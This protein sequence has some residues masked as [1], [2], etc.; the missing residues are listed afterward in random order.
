MNAQRAPNSISEVALSQLVLFR[1]DFNPLRQP[2]TLYW[3][4]QT[5]RQVVDVNPTVAG[6][7]RRLHEYPKMPTTFA[8]LECWRHLV[9]GKV[10]LK[11]EEVLHRVLI[12]GVNGD[13]LA[14]L[15]G[16]I[17]GV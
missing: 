13:P 6:Q 11:L 8:H 3:Y 4:A 14:S 15:R 16:G 2:N 9:L 5:Q 10:E 7:L 12:V 1:K 17:Y